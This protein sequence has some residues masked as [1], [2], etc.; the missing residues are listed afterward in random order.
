M[1]EGRPEKKENKKLIWIKES[2]KIYKTTFLS[3]D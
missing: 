2:F 3:H 1:N